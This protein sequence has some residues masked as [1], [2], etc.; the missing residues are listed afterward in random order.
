MSYSFDLNES[1]SGFSPS[2]PADGCTQC[3]IC[4]G[5]CPTFNKTED[6]EQSPM[7]RIRMI[8]A[9]DSGET[10][11]LSLEKLESCL[12]CYSCTTICPSK[13]NFENM[14]DHALIDIRKNKPLPFTTKV[15]L[16]L[17]LKP[18]LL[19]VMIQ[20]IVVAQSLGLRWLLDRM[21]VF[22]AIGLGRANQ[23]LGNVNFPATTI[24]NRTSTL[25]SAR[26]K[27]LMVMLN[28]TKALVK[29]KPISQR[30][31]SLFKGCFTSVLEQDVQQT[32]IEVLNSLGIE[33]LI[34]DGQTCCGAMHRHN[35]NNSQ[36]TKLAQKNIT[37]F[38]ALNCST[39]IS[40]SSG[41]G[42]SLQNYSQWLESEKQGFS[43]PVMDISH[44][45][46]NILSER[47]VVF[48][49]MHLNVAIHTPCSLKREEGQVDAVMALLKR[50]PGLKLHEIHD[51]PSCCGAGG[52][53]VL[54][55]PEMADTIRDDVIE[56][57]I[58]L[59]P[60]V[61]VSSNLGCAMHLR[62][63]LKQAGQDIP[64]EHPVQLISRAL[65]VEFVTINS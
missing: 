6:V 26:S 27:Q 65:Q 48:N 30:R 15:M 5:S 19:K 31:V 7:G 54:S 16:S 36:A 14:L 22:N 58:A 64:L 21:G 50:I 20:I 44:Y 41:C 45:L 9:L 12:G 60:D 59:K 11:G 28:S 62:A 40:T 57:V 63:G 8:R 25:A 43:Q 47:K 10:E 13:V 24:D 38:N 42:A 32:S 39:I 55:H 29:S 35:G 4:L 61:L 2:F 33:V 18:W 52:S 53:Q 49:T 17:S 3:G 51:A 1:F 34:P 56:K 46:E 23:L 37:S